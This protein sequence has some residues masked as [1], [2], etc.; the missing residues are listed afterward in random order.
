MP[1]RVV[2]G[3]RRAAADFP[4]QGR[5]A[6]PTR[7]GGRIA[8]SATWWLKT[9][10]RTLLW[11]ITDGAFAMRSMLPAAAAPGMVVVSRLRKDAHL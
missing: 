11:V 2:E 7:H 9:L 1:V 5:V 10:S 6:R 8:R 4:A 3:Y